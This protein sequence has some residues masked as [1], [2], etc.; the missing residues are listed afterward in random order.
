MLIIGCF[1]ELLRNLVSYLAG[2]LMLVGMARE[3]GLDL[4]VW[5]PLGIFEDMDHIMCE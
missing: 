5:L 2:E 4:L 3:V 1:R